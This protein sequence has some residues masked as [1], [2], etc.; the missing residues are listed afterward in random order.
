M[1]VLLTVQTLAKEF[2]LTFRKKNNYQHLICTKRQIIIR[3]FLG[4]C[5]DPLYIAHGNMTAQRGMTLHRFLK[6]KSYQQE[7]QKP[8]GCVIHQ[9]ELAKELRIINTIKGTLYKEVDQLYKH[10]NQRMH[11]KRRLT[12]IWKATKKE[13]KI[14]EEIL[15]HEFIHELLEDNNLRPRS[16]TYNE[17]LTT[18]LTHYALGRHTIFEQHLVSKEKMWNIYAL[19]AHQW[20]K[21]FRNAKTPKERKKIIQQNLK[22]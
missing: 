16:W 22:K 19:H 18:Y 1:R 10:I 6:S 20:A 13:Q 3:N 9:E 8:Q 17:G 7:L 14:F 15:L 12:L 11:H 2:N 21:L 5:P 4:Q